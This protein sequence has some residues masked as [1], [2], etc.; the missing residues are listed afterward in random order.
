MLCKNCKHFKI[1]SE[2]YKYIGYH[3]EPGQA[4]CDKYNLIVDFFSHK[5]FDNLTC[6]NERKEQRDADSY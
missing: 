5:K 1:Q 3:K 2:P 6:W 4:I